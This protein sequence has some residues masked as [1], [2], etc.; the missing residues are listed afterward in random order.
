MPIILPLT[1]YHL[2]GFLVKGFLD[3]GAKV[4]LEEL[5]QIFA[6]DHCAQVSYLRGHPAHHGDTGNLDPDLTEFSDL[7]RLDGSLCI[8]RVKGRL[9]KDVYSGTISMCN[10]LPSDA[11]N[12]CEVPPECIRKEMLHQ[13]AQRTWISI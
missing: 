11:R 4:F 7:E 13:K 9:K 6:V 1:C 2:Q 3:R 5:F 12:R 8:R 10:E